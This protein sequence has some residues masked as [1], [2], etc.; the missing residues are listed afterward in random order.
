MILCVVLISACVVSNPEE[1][2]V[3]EPLDGSQKGEST[4]EPVEVYEEPAANTKSQAEP[5]QPLIDLDKLLSGGPPPDGIPS[6]DTP[7]FNSVKEAD[8]W[9]E[10]EMDVFMIIHKGETRV[11]PQRIMVWHEIVNDNIKGDPILITYCPL[12]GSVIAYERTIDNEAIEF[13]TS[14]KLYNSA[15]VMYDR[16]TKSLWTQVKGQAVS[17]EQ[18]GMTLTPLS[19]DVVKWKD[20]KQH[21]PEAKVLMKDTVN[22]RAYQRDPY[23]EYYWL[24]RIMFPVEHTDDRMHGKTIV[25]GIKIKGKYKVYKQEDIEAGLVDTFN[26]VN[27]KAEMLADRRVVFT[28]TDTGRE[29]MKERDF[30]FCWWAYHPFSTVYEKV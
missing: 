17:G 1:P 3:R 12:C 22:P 10:D 11:Y 4:A 30:W 9:L 24:N 14:G 28:N 2:L 15:L 25:H 23:G 29:I 8:S 18:V 21:H 27:L 19:I 20:I 26:G 5:K 7:K 13:G 16:K 6:I